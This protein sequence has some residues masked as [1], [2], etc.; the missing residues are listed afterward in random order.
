MKKIIL[1]A[2]LVFFLNGVAVVNSNHKKTY[3]NTDYVVY[4]EPSLICDKT[5]ISLWKNPLYIKLFDKFIA[6]T[7]PDGNKI[8]IYAQKEI[9]DEQLLRAYAILGMYLNSKDKTIYAP[10]KDKIANRMARQGAVLLLLKGSDGE[11]EL[12]EEID[13]QPLFQKENPLDGSVAYLTN[14]YRYRDAAYEEI[15]HLV[16]DYGIGTR[17]ADGVL[18]KTFQKQLEEATDDALK[19]KLWGRGVEDW[20]QELREEGSLTQEYLA[21]LVDSYYGLWEN[22]RE[23]QGGMWGVYIA[24]NRREIFEKDSK[25]WEV[26]KQYFPKYLSY[27]SRIDPN[28]NGTFSISLNPKE[29]YTYKSQY[30]LNV[31]LT[32]TKASHLLG[33]MQDNI[34]IGNEGNNTLDGKGGVDTV[35]VMGLSTEYLIKRTAKNTLTITDKNNPKHMDTLIHIERIVFQDKTFFTRNF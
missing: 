4:P 17:Y 6:Y 15:L 10:F 25:G 5:Q 11:Y 1:S 28:F 13:G 35:Q 34:F 3:K 29:P 18:K 27:M 12:D 20:I 32:G 26:L 2:L 22:W 24:K 19:N 9:S 8:Y 33:N 14:D 7:T 23:A 16:H 21:S 31:R 30:L